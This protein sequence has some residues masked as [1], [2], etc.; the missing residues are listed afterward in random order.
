MPQLF[1]YGT[2]RTPV[3]GPPSDTRFHDRIAAGVT[4][5]RLAR[6]AGAVLYD[7]GSYPGV[8]PGDRE[9]VGEVFEVSEATLAD[10][11]RIEGHPDF[12]ER[13]LETV[14]AND[15]TEVEAWVYWAPDTIT[16]G[17]PIVPE[18]DWLEREHRSPTSGP[19][20]LPDDTELAAV[21]ARFAAEPC[22]WISSV[23]PDGRPHTAP[24]WHVMHGNRMYVVTPVGSVKRANVSANPAVVLALPDPLEVVII[25]GWAIDA[26][27]TLDEIRGLFAVKYGWDPGIETEGSQTIFEITPTRVLAWTDDG[28]QS[29]WSF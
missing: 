8:G 26:P 27:H 3:G 17:R 18:G 6:L 29:H 1:V 28:E 23:R 12:Y 13:R 5:R 20:E 2:L 14:V 19:L 24:M 21:L 11:D 15:G 25:E 16:A 22:S 7:F 10:A 4:E 9:V